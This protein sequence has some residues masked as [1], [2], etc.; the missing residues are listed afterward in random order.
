MPIYFS[1]EFPWNETSEGVPWPLM[2]LYRNCFFFRE[3]KG[4]L[5]VDQ[6]VKLSW[7]RLSAGVVC[8]YSPAPDEI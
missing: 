8:P 7:F 6:S 5:K 3:R 4:V 2:S 1:I